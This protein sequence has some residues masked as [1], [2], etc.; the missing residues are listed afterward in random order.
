VEY[1]LNPSDPSGIHGYHGDPDLDGLLNYEEYMGQD[2]SRAARNPHV[3]GTGDETNPNSHNWRP[4][5][6]GPGPGTQRPSIASNY[7]MVF[8]VS[9]T[10]GSLG[11]ALPTL[12]I[13]ADPGTDTDDDSI[14]D[15]T[16]IQSEY[17]GGETG[18]SP[19]HSMD[20]FVKRAARI[21]SAA[22]IRIPDPEGGVAVGGYSPLLHAR[23]WTVECSVKLFTNAATGYLYHYPGRSAGQIACQLA[24]SNNI[25]RVTFDTLGGQRY[26]VVGLSLPTN[27]WIHLAA[28]WSADDNTLSLVLDGTFIQQQRIYE[29]GLAGY[30]FAAF[31]NAVLGASVN[32]SFVGRVYL[33]EV[34]IWGTARTLAQLDEGKHALVSQTSESLLAYYRFDDGGAT[35]EDFARKAQCGL[36]GSIQT[37]YPF[38]DHGYALATNGFEFVTN[39]FAEVLGVHERGAD[40][41]DND[42]LPDAWE[43]INQLDPESDSGDDGASGDVDGDSLSNLS[44]YFSECNPR[45]QDTDQ[46]GLLDTQ[47][48]ADSDG[49]TNLREQ[50]LATRPDLVDTDDDGLSDSA[51][52]QNGSNPVDANS[53]PTDRAMAFDGGLNDYV[54][55]PDSVNQRLGTWTLEAWVNPTNASLGHGTVVSRDLKVISPTLTAANYTLGI[56]TNAGALIPQGGFVTLGGTAVLVAPSAGI[57]AGEW[58]HLAVVYDRDTRSLALFTNG[59]SAVVTNNI[60]IEPPLNGMVGDTALRMGRSLRGLVDE[61]R[62]WDLAR[63]EADLQDSKGVVIPSDTPGLVH[64]F[65]FD[66]GEAITNEFA[67]STYH[68]PHGAQ[69]LVWPQDFSMGKPTS[70]RP[71]TEPD[72]MP[73]PSA[74]T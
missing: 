33:D 20:P 37:N 48:D 40:D 12:S 5:S 17:R 34:R 11:S 9:P 56:R 63:S 49:L 42:G 30:P 67:F 29:E 65:R 7:W 74:S 66:D 2:G 36:L 1:N 70:P 10:N 31:T 47:E 39:D 22:G 54:R 14:P 32:S 72:S 73:H 68:Q 8:T 35:A 21:K 55:I 51:E 3:N 53:P 45:A 62:I 58:T 52:F 4:N 71:G 28:S 57:P 41:S 6:T 27:R 26:S 18:T 43:I 59:L 19:V 23:N 25:P 46:D 16:E 64:Y 44:E 69:D 61:V 38:G 13:G 24:L 60:L 15:A 50:D